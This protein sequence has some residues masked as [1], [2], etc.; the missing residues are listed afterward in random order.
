MSSDPFALLGLDRRTASETDVRKAYAERLKVTRPE[1]DRDGFMALRE[2]FERARQ[3]ARWR[4]EYPQ[5]D[6]DRDRHAETRETGEVAVVELS[7]TDDVDEA[8]DGEDAYTPTDFDQRI[9]TAMK[10][11]HQALTAPWG[12]PRAEN[13]VAM[14]NATELDG[15]D[16]YRAMQWQVRQF[17]CHATGYFEEGQDVVRPPWLTIEVFDTLDTQYGWTRQPSG[18]VSERHMNAWMREVRKKIEWHSITYDQR[19]ELERQKLRRRQSD[20]PI[21]DDYFGSNIWLFIGVGILATVVLRVLAGL[22]R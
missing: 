17:I 12:P 11:L 9:D 1:D 15:I 8:Y 22:G 14:L 20:Q 19:V 3:E 5:E 6:E 10:A 13:L 21:R 16:E 4:A 2:A 18:H 7:G